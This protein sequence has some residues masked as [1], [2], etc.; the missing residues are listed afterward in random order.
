ML[1]AS[2]GDGLVFDA[3]SL[4][5][6]GLAASEIDVGRREIVE[7]FVIAVVVVVGHEIGDAP[8]EITGQI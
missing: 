6:D 5:D 2:L 1:Q 3:V 4:L 7:T 8:F